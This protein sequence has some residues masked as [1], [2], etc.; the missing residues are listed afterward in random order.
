MASHTHTLYLL[1][2]LLSHI[3]FDIPLHPETHILMF[4]PV[5]FLL[6]L[7]VNHL[8]S[9]HSPQES[10]YKSTS[11]PPLSVLCPWV[12][13]ER[14]G[15]NTQHC[16]LYTASIQIR[17]FSPSFPPQESAFIP[18]C[19]VTRG[20]QQSTR[21][22]SIS[23]PNSTL[24]PKIGFTVCHSET[25]HQI[26][27]YMKSKFKMKAWLGFIQFLILQI[28]LGKQWEHCNKFNFDFLNL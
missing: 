18:F 7:R 17:L 27:I 10:S 6:Y 14:R 5:Y 3:L 24:S 20:W 15:N 28:S 11:Y 4:S 22:R 25:Y 2:F 8:C 19:C 1:S 9:R 23:S 16:N 12:E 26:E 21:D 13:V